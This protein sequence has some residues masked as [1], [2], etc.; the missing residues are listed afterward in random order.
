MFLC[1]H[2]DYDVMRGSG[3]LRYARI[4]LVYVYRKDTHRMHLETTFHVYKNV[5]KIYS[6]NTYIHSAYTRI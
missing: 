5:F 3:R 2:D 6:Q 1:E 4:L